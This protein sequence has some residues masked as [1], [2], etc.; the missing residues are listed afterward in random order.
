MT[1]RYGN[2]IKDYLI[3]IIPYHILILHHHYYHNIFIHII[4]NYYTTLLY[5]FT[6]YHFDISLLSL[7]DGSF[8]F[9]YHGLAGLAIWW[10]KIIIWG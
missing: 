8:Y 9:T 5:T 6:F 1:I 10:V 3:I 2:N 7:L 4:T